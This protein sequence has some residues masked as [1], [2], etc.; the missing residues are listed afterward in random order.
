M[1][2]ALAAGETP[3][4]EMVAAAG[5]SEGMRP[6]WAWVCVGAIFACTATLIALSRGRSLIDR[7]SEAKAPAVLEDRARSLVTKLGYSDAPVDRALGY[8]VDGDYRAWAETNKPKAERFQGVETGEPP[9]IHLWFRQSPRPLVSE[10]MSGEVFYTHPPLVVS[11]MA[12]VR[13]DLAGRLVAFYAVPPQVESDG[14]SPDPDWS[15]LFEEAGLDRAAFKEVEPRWTPSS[16]GDARAAWEGAYPRRPDIPVRIEAAAHRGK[17]VSFRMVAPW[18]RP[19]RMEPFQ[20]RPGQAAM[21]MAFLSLLALLITAGAAP[22]PAQH[23]GGPGRPEGSLSP[24]RRHLRP[25]VRVLAAA[26]P[27]RGRP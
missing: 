15:S 21:Q 7:L 11:G 6:F 22:G 17:P 13:L 1:A 16:F 3:S 27:P 25:G 8:G 19:E 12:G 9:I 26:G 20:P 2:A 23:Q 24:R 14:P 5:R 18:T 10:R 4:P